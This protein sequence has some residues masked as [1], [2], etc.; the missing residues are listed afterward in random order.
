MEWYRFIYQL[1]SAGEVPESRL[2]RHMLLVFLEDVRASFMT[3]GNWHDRD[4]TEGD[5]AIIPAY[6]LLPKTRVD[7]QFKLIGL[8]LEPA[9]LDRAVGESADADKIELIP[10]LKLRDPLIQEIGLALKRELEAIGADSKLY[11]ESMAIALSVHLLQRYGTRK[12][13]IREYTGGLRDV[14]PH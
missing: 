11:A 2:D 7:R 12:Q 4:Y 13:K 10:Q 1:E 9:T 3:D 6:E 14:L 8:S 5:I